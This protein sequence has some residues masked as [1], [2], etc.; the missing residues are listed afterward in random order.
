MHINDYGYTLS[1]TR[2]TK[3]NRQLRMKIISILFILSIQGLALSQSKKETQDWI[4]EKIE[5]FAYSNDAANFGHEYEVS[6]TE[7]EMR[8]Y[9]SYISD[10]DHPNPIIFI[11][12]IPVKY[13][14]TVIFE[15]KTNTTW[16]IISTSANNKSIVKKNEGNNSIEYVDHVNLIFYKSVNESDMKNRL[17]KAFKN[18]V[19]VH[20]GI[21]VE[22]KF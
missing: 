13:L 8:L 7:N 20:G 1:A 5:V 3:T 10:Y 21:V 4:K 12:L 6:F 22:E 14:S 18:L 17:I 19:K 11:Y 15:E 9:T 2:N 16:M